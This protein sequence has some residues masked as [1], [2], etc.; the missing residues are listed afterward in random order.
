MPRARS[1]DSVK[2]EEMYRTGMSLTDI[3]EKLGVSP[4]TV[5]SW[6]NRQKWDGEPEPKK[7]NVAKKKTASKSKKKTAT[8]QKKKSGGQP[9][10][11]NAVG[12]TSSKPRNQKAVKHGAY[13]AVFFNY[14]GAEDRE[15][16][17]NMSDVDEED[18]LL[19]EI[20]VLTIRERRILMAIDEQRKKARHGM[21]VSSIEKH[22]EKRDFDGTDEEKAAQKALYEEKREKNDSMPGFKTGITTRSEHVLELTSRLDRELTSVQKQIA[23]D[24]KLLA[25]LREQRKQSGRADQLLPLQIER[26]DAEI[27]RIDAQTSRLLGVNNEFED[28]SEADDLLYGSGSEDAYAAEP[29]D[30]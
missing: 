16:L 4:G 10:N 13:R 20:Q 18:H 1:P 14:L 25:D 12:N 2:A 6:K 3:A 24:L 23:H 26:L 30:P 7:R 27:E 17:E 15:L 5:R 21:Y 9:G 22:D 19:K 8:L 28:T 11:K 29:Q